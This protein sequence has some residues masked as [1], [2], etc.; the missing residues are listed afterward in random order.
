[1][2]PV[3]SLATPLSSCL[4][5]CHVDIQRPQAYTLLYADNK[6]LVLHNK[7][8]LE[9]FSKSGMIDTCSTASGWIWMEQNF[10]LQI[11]IK[12]AATCS[13]S[14]DWSI[15]H[16]GSCLRHQYSL[17]SIT[18][19]VSN[20][21]YTAILSVLSSSVVLNA[22]RLQKMTPRG[23]KDEHFALDQWRNTLWS[24][25]KIKH[26][27]PICG[28]THSGKISEQETSKGMVILKRIL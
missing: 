11:L 19:N 8:H 18:L 3:C 12:Q 7:V 14:N 10:W 16:A 26:P 25:P 22:R 9:Q 24:H 15:S 20:S 13:K 27:R 21:N 1:M 17:D 6:F 2:H 28:W 5:Q 23:N 4:R